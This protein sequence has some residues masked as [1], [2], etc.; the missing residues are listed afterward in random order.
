[1][2]EVVSGKTPV[3]GFVNKGI[4]WNQLANS[5]TLVS[6][7]CLDLLIGCLEKNPEKRIV[8]SKLCIHPW[9]ANGI[10]M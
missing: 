5:R 3:S 2:F 8:L 7:M 9:I 1:M 6:G 10:D 4:N